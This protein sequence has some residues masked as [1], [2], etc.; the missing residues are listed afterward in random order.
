MNKKKKFVTNSEDYRKYRLEY[1]DSLL[2][3][4]KKYVHKFDNALD[5]VTASGKL[6]IVLNVDFNKRNGVEHTNRSYIFNNGM[7]L[8]RFV[9]ERI[10][11]W[12]KLY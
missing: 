12:I 4:L 3:I 9:V 5:V 6:T 7:Y 8:K 11:A 1:P 10:N 2:D